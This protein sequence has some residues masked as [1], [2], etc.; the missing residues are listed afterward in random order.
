MTMQSTGF[1]KQ[2]GDLSHIEVDKVFG[3]VSD[4]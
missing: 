2:D 4:I 1:K 3:L